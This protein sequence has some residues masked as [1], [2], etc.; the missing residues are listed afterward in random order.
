MNTEGVFK[1]MKRAIEGAPRN[2]YVAELHLQVIKYADLLEGTSGREFCEK[3]DLK[4]AWG[5]EFAKMK[6]IAGRLRDAGLEPERI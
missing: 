3:L 6:K 1:R 2:G 5:T 4:P